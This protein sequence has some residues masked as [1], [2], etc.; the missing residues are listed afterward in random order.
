MINGRGNP[1]CWERNGPSTT[2]SITNLAWTPLEM[3]LGIC[4]EKPGITRLRY[5]TDLEYK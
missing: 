5:G 2:M 1:R 3:N 4:G